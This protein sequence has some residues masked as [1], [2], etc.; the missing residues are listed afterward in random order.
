MR[1]EDK[2]KVV[3]DLREKFAKTKVLIVTDYKGLP[4][5]SLNGLRR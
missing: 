2:K 4:V 1:L 3:E 5:E